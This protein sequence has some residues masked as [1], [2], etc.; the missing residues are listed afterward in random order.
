MLLYFGSPTMIAG[1]PAR[2]CDVAHALRLHVQQ[3][4]SS[5]RRSRDGPWMASAVSIS[6]AAG[7]SATAADLAYREAASQNEAARGE[8]GPL[9]GGGML[10]YFGS[11]TYWR[12]GAAASVT[13]LTLR[14]PRITDGYGLQSRYRQPGRV[15]IHPA[16]DWTDVLVI[17]N[18]ARDNSGDCGRR[19]RPRKADRRGVGAGVMCHE[20]ACVALM[21]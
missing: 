14:P 18:L 10:L 5:H 2:V 12:V 16:I 19:R 1:A 17:G 13:L 4:A 15:S 9:R 6:T 7:R 3:R 21:E 8:R 20:G 11:I